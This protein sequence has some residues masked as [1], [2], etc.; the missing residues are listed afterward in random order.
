MLAGYPLLSLSI[1]VP[2]IAGVLVLATGSDRN[3]PLAR[4][5]A[6]LGAI[7]G[8]AVTLPLYTRFEPALRQ[9]AVHRTGTLD[10]GIQ[11]SLSPWR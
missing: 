9:H 4:W 6:L 7:L 5:I 11:Y 10:P 1:W 2:I 8:F 3:A